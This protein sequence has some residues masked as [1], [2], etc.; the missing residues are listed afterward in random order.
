MAIVEAI[1]LQAMQIYWFICIIYIFMSWLPNAR[2]SN[3]G[4]T[5]SKIVE[6]YFAP[7]RQ[8]IPPLGMIDLSPL[9]AI[10]ALRFAMDGVRYLF[11]FFA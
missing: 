11:S 8:I 2:E 10:F 7:F 9:V 3:F 1:V 4:Q 6:P 5:I